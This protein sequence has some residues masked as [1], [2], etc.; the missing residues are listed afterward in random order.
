M[1]NLAGVR[2]RNVLVEQGGPIERVQVRDF[3]V[4]GRRMFQANALLRPGLTSRRH[5]YEIYGNGDGT[6]TDPSPLVAKHMAISEAMERWAF[7]AKVNAPDGADYGFDVDRS[8]TGMAAFPGWLPRQARTKA[9]HEAVERFS[10]LA[11]WDGK[12]GGALRDTEWP[13][14]MAVQIDQVAEPMR[15]V[16]LFKACEPGFYAYGH[17]AAESFHRACEKAIL[18]LARN[19]YVMRRY[20]LARN[21][22][23]AYAQS[24]PAHLFER[25]ALYF[26]TPTGHARFLTRVREGAVTQAPRPEPDIVF[27]GEIP[28]PWSEYA[29]VWRVAMRPPAPDY[30]ANREDFFFW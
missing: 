28:G 19:E 16:V 23:E 2:F 18:E 12:L 3:R 5:R 13:D 10:L 25:R 24:A 1:L 8:T 27:D 14:V 21:L 29:S 9:W 4:F 7:H 15:A 6:G 22:P 26:S 11:W 17:A 30:L 20:L